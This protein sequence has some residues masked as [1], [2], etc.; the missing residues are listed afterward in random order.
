[1]QEEMMGFG[2]CRVRR[3]ALAVIGCLFLAG[4]SWA[5]D[6][7]DGMRFYQGMD[8]ENAFSAFRRAAEKGNAAAQ[9]ALGAMYYNGEG[10]GEDEAM[11][12]H[13]YLKAAEH[14]RM[15]AQFALAEMYEAGEGVRQ[16]LKKAA[17]WYKKAA[18]QGHLLAQ[19]NLGILYME[20]RGV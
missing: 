18:E 12:A 15:D 5:G 1:M 4:I 17:F 6:Y 8:Y 20:G 16:D 13:W 2:V 10:T 14:G 11:A 7:S 19:T 3:G 9:S